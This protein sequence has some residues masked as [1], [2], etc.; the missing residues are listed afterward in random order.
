MVRYGVE[1]HEKCDI[2]S[3]A[4]NDVSEVG[5]VLD[6]IDDFVGRIVDDEMELPNA[7]AHFDLWSGSS[8]K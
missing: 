7:S 1:C 8:S 3:N 6:N 2:E 5:E 4:L